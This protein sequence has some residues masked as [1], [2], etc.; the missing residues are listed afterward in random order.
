MR[1]NFNINFAIQEDDMKKTK[2]KWILGILCLFLFTACSTEASKM[3][4]RGSGLSE[5]KDK[6]SAPMIFKTASQY[7]PESLD[8]H[9]DYR[10]WHTS[11]YGITETLF[12]IQDDFSL[13]PLL[14]ESGSV[15][16]RTWT[17]VLK[18]EAAFSNGET[19][20]SE[21]VIRNLKRLSIENKR[22]AF[23]GNFQYEAID[24]KKLSITTPTVFPT[25]LNVLA[26]CETAM[27]HLDKTTDM[28]RNIIATGP[29]VVEKFDKD[30]STSVVKNTKY[31][32]GDVILDKAIFYKMADEDAL[33]MAMQNGEIDAY[34][35]VNAAAKSI[36][37]S[38]SSQYTLVSVPATRL[39]LYFLNQER[40][41]A[42]IRKAILLMFDG[43][44]VVDFLGGTVSPAIGPFSVNSAY[45]KVT[46]PDPNIAEAKKV[47][48]SE[49]YVKNSAGYYEKEGHPLE[50]NLAYYPGRSL[51][52]LATVMQEELEKNG[53][54]VRLTSEESP[55]STY[56]KTRDFDIA[57]YSMNADLTG[58]PEYFIANTLKTGAFYNVGGFDNESCQKLIETLSVEMDVEKRAELGN[59]IIQMAIDDNAHGY[60]AIFNKVTVLR[61]GV[62]GFAES[63]PF[64]FFGISAE[65]KVK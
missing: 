48:E 31:W 53:I 43:N 33:L 10:G 23:L 32:N 46:K 11:T 65:T 41:S 17:I 35:G 12:Q 28:D 22:F 63:S 27:I 39:Q 58:D 52:I 15:K 19:L 29:F 37:E 9:K 3:D 13:K 57:L 26:S 45:G 6:E 18:E 16:D 50:L 47:L 14:A 25:M 30:L 4:A 38:D 61:K 44:K 54:K 7:A 49:G 5:V 21:M 8:P 2:V 24:E 55:D 64:D 36:F 59:Q 56:I 20:T 51:D 1:I 34:Q 42:P 62:S 40:L 60:V